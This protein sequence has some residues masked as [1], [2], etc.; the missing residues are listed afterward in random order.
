MEACCD[1]RK[2]ASSDNRNFLRN[3]Y[4]NR[5]C[6]SVW[7]AEMPSTLAPVPDPFAQEQGG[8][9]LRADA[10]PLVDRP[11]RDF[12][13]LLIRC[14]TC[15]KES[16]WH[17][18]QLLERGIWAV[19]A[20]AGLNG[21]LKCVDCAD[22]GRPAREVSVRPWPPIHPGFQQCGEPRQ[23]SISENASVGPLRPAD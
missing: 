10:G 21:K 5:N 9:M 6:G 20:L 14:R 15:G 22:E 16:R 13:A 4:R 8:N 12:S 7:K 19:S 11:L 3:V 18:D 1:D 2:V 17:S 23:H